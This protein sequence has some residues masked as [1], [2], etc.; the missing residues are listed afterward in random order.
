M[1]YSNTGRDVPNKGQ[2]GLLNLMKSWIS[3]MYGHDESEF[4]ALNYEN[5]I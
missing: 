2:G 5:Q 4:V 3:R 1:N